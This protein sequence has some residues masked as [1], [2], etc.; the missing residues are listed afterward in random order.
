MA[1]GDTYARGRAS[2]TGQAA[3]LLFDYDPD[4]QYQN[5]G[6]FLQAAELIERLREVCVTHELP[7]AF[8][9]LLRTL[10]ARWGEGD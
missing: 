1:I 9:G 7:A 2:S 8:N 3:V 6:Y 4:L 5:F 10:H